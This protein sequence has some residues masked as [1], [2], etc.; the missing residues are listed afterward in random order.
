MVTLVKILVAI[1][2]ILVAVIKV[3]TDPALK[4]FLEG[5]YEQ[6]FKPKTDEWFYKK[7]GRVYG[8]NTG[9]AKIFVFRPCFCR[10]LYIDISLCL[11]YNYLRCR[12]GVAELADARDLKSRDSNIVPVQARSPA[13]NQKNPNIFP[14]RKSVRIF[15]CLILR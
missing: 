4:E 8:M 1:I 14:L 10:C 3:D 5:V 2:K 7:A 15:S 6:Y 12:A 13:P 11:V 9:G